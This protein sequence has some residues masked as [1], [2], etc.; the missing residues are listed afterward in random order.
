MKQFKVVGKYVNSE[1]L[2]G[3]ILAKFK[4]DTFMLI[5]SN[6]IESF[7][8]SDK[9]ENLHLDINNGNIYY[10]VS[11]ADRLAIPFNEFLNYVPTFDKKDIKSLF[12]QPD[13]IA[14]SLKGTEESAFL[15]LMVR[16]T[17]N[18]GELKRIRDKYKIRHQ[19]KKAC[20]FVEME[21]PLANIED[22]LSSLN[23]HNYGIYKEEN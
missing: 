5:N 16:D 3:I 4:F 15:S 6:Q 13:Y 14:M 23:T 7:V 20:N 8:R 9:I 21:A 10:M 11:M 1:G 2:N 17:F 19:I 22:Y 12:L 18:T